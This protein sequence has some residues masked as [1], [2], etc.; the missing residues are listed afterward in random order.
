MGGNL[1]LAA[2]QLPA[3]QGNVGLLATPRHVLETMRLNVQIFATTSTGVAVHLSR[4][5]H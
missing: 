4:S 1:T 5:V 2:L 3:Q